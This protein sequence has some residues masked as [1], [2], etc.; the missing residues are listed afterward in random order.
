MVFSASQLRCVT[1][2]NAP[3]IRVEVVVRTLPTKREVIKGSWENHRVYAKTY[4]GKNAKKYCERDLSGVQLLYS[5]NISTPEL[6]YKGELAERNGYA[7]VF[8]AVEPSE[9]LEMQWAKLNKSEQFNLAKKLVT[10]IATHH[11]AELVQT[12]LYL[13]NFLSS[14]DVIYTLDGD[15]IRHYSPLSTKLAIL[16]L[17][18]LLSKFDVLD[19]EV[20]LPALIMLYQQNRDQPVNLN[21]NRVKWITFLCRRRAAN[22]YADKKV[23]RTCSDVKVASGKNYS[24]TSVKF[25]GLNLPQ[26]AKQYDALIDSQS[27]VLKAGNT[28]TVVLVS[29]V[30]INVVIK[31]YNI[32]ST[33]HA[34][35]RM[36][37]KTRAAISWANAHRLQLLGV[38]TANPIA[39]LEKRMLGILRGKAYFISQ[40]VDA[41]DINVFF[42]DAVNKE[43]RSNAI[44]QVVQLFYRL[45]LLKISHGDMK[46][47]NIKVL[48]DGK[49]LL[50]DLDAM[51]QHKFDFFAEKAHV[52][53]I[54]RFM[55]NWKDEPSL[56]N[57]FVKVFKVVYKDH[58]PLKAAHILE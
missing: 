58:A 21:I 50:I 28:C 18:L 25:I 3:P 24:A 9:N 17:C 33:G 15:G 41:P 13:K 37:R 6:L 35:S 31:R 46:A 26:D 22:R 23:F 8:K 34:I 16:N 30:D 45:Y 44:K 53:D 56:Y 55:Q 42:E 11:N 19:L 43:I 38:A 54:K 29:M 10:V 49:P 5:A 48:T 51:Q 36:F 27:V 47:T 52:R 4:F 57:A 1:L 20:W 7:L 12:D 32:K 40:Y 2:K 14:H 39:L